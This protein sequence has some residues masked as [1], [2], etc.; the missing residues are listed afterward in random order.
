MTTLSHAPQ[1]HAYAVCPPEQD[2]RAAS[3]ASD[4]TSG[5]T[6]KGWLLSLAPDMNGVIATALRATASGSN[7]EFAMLRNLSPADLE[8]RL[9]AAG[10]SGLAPVISQHAARLRE[11]A[12][13]TGAELNDKFSGEEGTFQLA[14]GSLETFYGGLEVISALI[15]LR[16]AWPAVLTIAQLFTGYDRPTVDGQGPPRHVDVL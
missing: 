2:N 9:E 16:C 3:T 4:G 8:A 10:L 11:Q 13:A 15:L 5:W 6:A 1:L 14:F 7:D 12:A